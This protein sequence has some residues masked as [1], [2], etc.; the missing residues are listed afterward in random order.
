MLVSSLPS[1]R[2][3]VD[4]GFDHRFAC[5]GV[6]ISADDEVAIK[7]ALEVS[8]LGSSVKTASGTLAYQIGTS[9]RPEP[10]GGRYHDPEAAAAA[11][12]AVR[13]QGR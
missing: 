9:I 3:R 10:P 6:D 7:I 11:A 2:F 1:A 8:S 5:E 4:R 13:N 12:Q